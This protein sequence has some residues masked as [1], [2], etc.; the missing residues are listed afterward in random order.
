MNLFPLFVDLQD[1]RVLVVGGGEVAARKAR[2][3]LAASARVI[4]GAPTFRHDLLQAAQRGDLELRHGP[5]DPTWLE[6]MWLVVAATD[7]RDINAR[8]AAA[9][10]AQRCWVNVVDDPELSQV[11]VPA[12]VDRDPI[13]IAISSRGAAPMFARRLREQIEAM[14]PTAAGTLAAL[15]QRHRHAIRERFA[16]LSER[17][18]FYEQLWEG[19]VAALVYAGH[20][21]R[22]EAALLAALEARHRTAPARLVLLGVGPGDPDALTLGGLR[23]L[24]QADVIL[25]EASVPAAILALARR[26]AEVLPA[27]AEPAIR[28]SR[29]S[30]ML[31]PGRCVVWASPGSGDQLS[32]PPLAAPTL[33]VRV[34]GL[35][36]SPEAE[37][38]QH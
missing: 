37:A 38:R 5:F 1:R 16:D 19:D 6:G 20:S 13:T 28:A 10:T 17:R 9:A 27:P 35:P 3:L 15:A 2:A 24:N 36:A 23:A 11:Q 26:D 18:R 8:V 14:V 21:D 7:R 32:A 22:A 31:L 34:P 25:A 4:V 30:E 33:V 12:V 29:L